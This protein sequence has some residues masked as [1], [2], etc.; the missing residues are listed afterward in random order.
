VLDV[1]EL[2]AGEAR[3][4]SAYKCD[5]GDKEE[6]ARVALE[7]E[8]DVSLATGIE[9]YYALEF[10]QVEAKSSNRIL[11]LTSSARQPSSSTMQQLSMGSA[12]S[13]S[14]LMR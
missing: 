10:L 6:L 4:V 7:I 1:K 14:H 5:V 2:E 12:S 8:R 13:I 9:D 11:T 3:G